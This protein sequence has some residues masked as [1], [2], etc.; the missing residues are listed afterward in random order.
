MAFFT[1]TFVNLEVLFNKIKNDETR[2]AK[3]SDFASHKK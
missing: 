1:R 2:E 3:K